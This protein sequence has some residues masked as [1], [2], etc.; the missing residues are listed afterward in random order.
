MSAS[1]PVDGVD[2]GGAAKMKRQCGS[3][4][5]QITIGSMTVRGRWRYSYN[6]VS[7]VVE[8]ELPGA[9]AWEDFLFVA[10]LTVSERKKLANLKRGDWTRLTAGPFVDLPVWLKDIEYNDSNV[11]VAVTFFDK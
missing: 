3:S 11:T 10:S 2:G 1:L 9:T 7:E 6:H 5:G 8:Q 4:F